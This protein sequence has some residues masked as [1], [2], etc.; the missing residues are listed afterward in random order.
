MASESGMDIITTEEARIPKGSN[1]SKTKSIAIKKSFARP[2][3]LSFTFSA[4]SKG[5]TISMLLGNFFL[6]ASNT[7]KY[8]FW[9]FDIFSP[10]F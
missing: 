6:Y 9:V 2:P 1:V 7:G 4:W 10:P 3:S 8:S 5:I